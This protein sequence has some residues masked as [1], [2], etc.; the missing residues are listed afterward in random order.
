MKGKRTEIVPKLFMELSSV[1]GHGKM[2]GYFV[3][4]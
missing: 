1:V 2:Y 3:L 4:K